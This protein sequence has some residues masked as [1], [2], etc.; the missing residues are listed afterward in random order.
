MTPFS[1]S[2]E[3]DLIVRR[4]AMLLN[5]DPLRAIILRDRLLVLI[6]DGA[7][8]LLVD[9]ERRVR[10]GSKELEAHIFG[11]TASELDKM[12]S[13]SNSTHSNNSIKDSTKKT[14]IINRVIQ[15][16]PLARQHTSDDPDHSSK[17][18][19]K[20]KKKDD[21]PKETNLTNATAEE[22][23]HPH[24][25][26]EWEDLK[27]KEWIQLPFELQCADAV[28]QTVVGLLQEDTHELQMATL[29]YIEQI[30]SPSKR[31][32]YREDPLTII[33]AVKDSVR[34]MTARVK[35]FVKSM[36]DTL[37]DYEDMALMNL[38]R[39]ITVP[40]RFIQPVPQEVLEEESDEPELILESYLQH[41]MSVM[42]VLDLIQGQIDTA[43]ELVDQKLDATRNK[44]LLANTLITLTAFCIQC[45]TLV[46]GFL[47]MNLTNHMEQSEDA[48]NKVTYWT[49]AATVILFFLLMYIMQRTETMPGWNSFNAGGL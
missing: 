33:R 41:A 37:D 1:A 48:F 4:H 26:S 34:E 19:K 18:K 2:N 31:R 47:G 46:A 14:S 32:G 25:Q 11:V 27:G 16:T 24:Y 15:K 8:S 10:G 12:D 42:N 9:L 6:P 5:F 45:A 29:D 43:A 44:I 23:D 35:G 36:N 13:L 49:L 20:K 21:T 17:V 30:I 40:E 28:L 7:D 3:P 38:S 22:F 39:L